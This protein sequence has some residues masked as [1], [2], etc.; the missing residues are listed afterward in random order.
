AVQK[1]YTN[2]SGLGGPVSTTAISTS[3]FQIVAMRRNP[4][5]SR[6]EIWVDG[7]M[8]GTE[9][10]TGA[11]LNP[12]PIVIAR[13]A[14]DVNGGFNGEIAELLIY[15]DELE[16]AEFNAVG[17]YL[18]SRYGLDT[19]FPGSTVSTPITETGEPAYLRNE[20]NYAGN[21]ATTSVRLNHALSDGAVFY[22]NGVEISRFNMPAG[23][24]DHSTRALSD[25]ET[26]SSS[27][28]VTLPAAMLQTGSNV[29]AVSLHPAAGNSSVSFS[30]ALEGTELPPSGDD[31]SG[32]VFHEISPAGDAGF[33]VELTNPEAVPID[34]EDYVLVID[35]V[36]PGSVALPAV[37]LAPGGLHTLH[38]VDLGQ[39]PSDGDQLYLV[40][41]ANQAPSD[42]RRVTNRLRGR[43]PGFGSEWL[44]PLLATPGEANVFSFET[45]VVIN[46]ICYNAPHL[47]PTPG[48]PP[49][50]ETVVLLSETATWRYN[51][52]GA[53]LGTDWAATAHPVGG[54]W[55]SGP[56]ILAYDTDLAIPFGTTLD[57]PAGNFPS[58]VTYYFETDF[59]LSAS[60]VSGLDSLSL[61]YLID[62]GAVF[63]LNGVELERVNLNAGVVTSGTFA[64]T[65]VGD[66]EFSGPV[67]VVVPPGTAVVG[68]NRFSVEVHQ[69]T[70]GSSDLVFGL[71]V[72]LETV[73]DPGIPAQP[74]RASDEQWIELYNRGASEVDLSGWNFG[75]GL[76]F[77]FPVG[78]TLAANAYLVVARDPVALAAAHPAATVY[79]PF[80][81]SLDRGSETL[82]LRD[83]ANNPADSLRYVDGGNWPSLAD[84]Q[85]ST[86]ELCDPRSDNSQPSAWAASDEMVRTSWQTYSYRGTASAS[87]VGPDGQW[88]DFVFGLLEEGEVLL[89]DISVVENPD[90]AAI[91]FLSDGSF[92]G[93]NLNAWRFVGNHRD[94][95]IIPDPDGGGNVLRLRATGSTEHMHNHAETT[96]A[97]G[98]QV[99]NGQEYEISFRARWLGGS[100]QLHTR[101][102]FN[103][104]AHTTRLERPEILGTPGAP[105][106]TLVAN[107]GPT[108]QSLSHSPVVPAAG[109]PVTVS[110]ELDDPDGTDGADLF[111]AVNGGGFS[112]VA[113]IQRAGSNFWD[114]S[115]PGESAGRVVQ[116][117]VEAR[118][119][120]GQTTFF[121]REGAESRAMYQVEDGRA[122][123]T[124]I[125]NIRIIMDPNDRVW[126]HTPRNVMNN[127]R[128]PCTVI[129]RENTVYYNAGVRIKGSQRARLSSSR[130]GFNLSFPKD[131]LYRA[132]HRTM[133]ID[134]SEGQNV[135]QR[136]I[137][138]DLMATSS[139]GVPAEHNDLCYVISP[140]PSHTSAAVLQM[141]RYGSNFLEDQFENGSD[142][143]VYEYELVY[144]PTTA[145]AQG[146]K[147]P[148]PDAVIGKDI[149]SMGP[150]PEN[151][152]WTYQV[153]NNQESDN[154]Q[155]MIDMAGLFDLSDTAFQQEVDGL[156]DVD[157]WLRALAY[158][159]ATGAGDSFFSNSNHNG[160]FYA[161]PDGKVLY[162][163]HDMDFAFSATRN[164]FENSE[165]SKITTDP[166][167]R[168]RYLGHLHDICTTVY[169]QGW[170]S[171]WTSHYDD[172]VPGGSV[173]SDDLSY[174]NSRSNYILGQVTNSV[175]T[176]SFAIT[177][178]GGNDFT[179][180]TSPVVLEGR[181]WIDVNEIRLAGSDQAIPVTWTSTNEWQISVAL[182][183]GANDLTVE[184]YDFS[185]SLLEFDTIT[186]TSTAPST[187]PSVDNLVVSE[188]YYNP[189]GG[190]EGAEYLEFLNIHVS[191]IL[192]LTGLQISDGISFVFPEGTTLAPGER[193]L[194]VSNLGE[195]EN[196][197]GVGLP[198]AGEFTNQ[199]GNGGDTLTIR[200]AGGSLVRTFSYS[201]DPP[202]PTIADGDGASLVLAVPA[203][204]PNHSLPESWRASSMNGGTPGTDD[205]IT[206]ASWKAGFGNPADDA[207]PE[208]DG[209]SVLEEFLL[210]GSPLTFDLLGP[211]TGFD[212]VGQQFTGS[213][214][215]RAGVQ[216]IVTLESSVDLV[217]WAPDANTVFVGRERLSATIDRLT[218]TTTMNG[219]T[220]YY[221]FA[222]E[223]V[224]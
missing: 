138:F 50:V 67:S 12:Q 60:E 68:M 210:G 136:E 185:G 6:F 142:G 2:G 172:L 219:E 16:E 86:L 47:D 79:G 134:R 78:T 13:H 1:R 209:W 36:I 149:T 158:S 198:V 4:G 130:I 183:S 57:N 187:V 152:R 215:L 45:E 135:G 122:A 223:L 199:L 140:D 37:S 120:P 82:T 77:E 125:N 20:F 174:I 171:D 216:V 70:L 107:H 154:L 112:S 170:M 161:R 105:N 143:T 103:R 212:I 76:T 35:G 59:A 17:A 46:E 201:D 90:G 104:L 26:P 165:L 123:T 121:P 141:A 207:D 127:G 62:D 155:P 168:R 224:E 106:S 156:L 61:N 64:N 146:Y 139:G 110:V 56:G 81:G 74:V 55:S 33:F 97:N 58:V 205:T 14:T 208:G 160:Q 186:V 7:V 164:I 41:P 88:R 99:A 132:A 109:E 222:F 214:D 40:P 202:W 144:Y 175:P 87:S 211:Q 182:A 19:A 31:V 102:Y 85:G 173:F 3:D 166:A 203:S 113:M 197:F 189:P 15:S 5:S 73:T 218:M 180:A 91:Q 157:Q 28:F 21:A 49:T 150:D 151:Y 163:P 38:V 153:K 176:V 190:S 213:V 72:S 25:V 96:L 114:G 95:E 128:L 63:Y 9:G 167:R 179:T 89:D 24:V 220:R 145:D 194:V 169:N 119:V 206:F 66:A 126:M 221:R 23:I 84:G 178:N 111:Y 65:G 200:L 51:Q 196:A 93:G 98:E 204:A 53:N 188:I 192:D 29:L 10:D 44:F 117:Y 52:S 43:A 148:N 48:V 133:A 18:E 129:D 39:V 75:E 42:A 92:E 30:A 124:G 195:F 22:L 184:A 71:E 27:G 101:L 131:N 177:T 118:D 116:F 83:A 32:P 217:N 108:G 94:A 147:L 137:L 69:N 193:V 181:G 115:I 8:E 34:L 191:D 159:C 54:S 11:G 100:P 80:S 162:F